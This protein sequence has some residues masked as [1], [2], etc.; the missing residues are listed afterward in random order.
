MQKLA[1]TYNR[2]C[3]IT[4][5]SVQACGETNLRETHAK[6]YY[7][8]AEILVH[9]R[10][11]FRTRDLTISTLLIWLSWAVIGLAYPLFN[12]FLPTYLASRGAQFNQLSTDVTWRNY[13]IVNVCSIFGPLVAG[14][15]ALTFLGRKYTMVIGALATMAF[16]WAYSTVKSN[17]G[18][19]A[20]A[21]M[22]TFTT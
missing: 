19:V 17:E 8:V 4:L 16:S 5:E 10:G 6:N 21:C 15:M 20:F 2:P 14:L 9:V 22:I 1:K 13:A 18:N 7:S 3:S 12:V 11:L